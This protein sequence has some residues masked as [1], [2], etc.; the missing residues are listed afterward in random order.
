VQALNRAGKLLAYHDRSDGG[1]FV[2]M[3][4]MAFAGQRG[5]EIVF[6]EGWHNG[7]TE[8]D[9]RVLF[10]EELGA[11]LQVKLED[12][13]WVQEVL[14]SARLTVHVVARVVEGDVVAI[15]QKSDDIYAE[16]RVRLQQMWSETSFH[17]QSLRDNPACAAEEFGLI[18]DAGRP[19]LFVDV[20]RRQVRQGSPSRHRLCIR[21]GL[22]LRCC[23]S[24]A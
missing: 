4:E 14:R 12:A 10:N 5:L 21:R 8:D 13:T 6:D 3:A 1:V 11:V 22:A 20:P 16:S 15:S 7:S 24:R 18:A 19:G 23:A 2:T 9:L 17:V